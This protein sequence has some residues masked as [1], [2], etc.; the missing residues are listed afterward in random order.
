MRCI[1]RVSH[2]EDSLSVI[3]DEN[4]PMATS[5][6][7]TFGREPT[8]AQQAAAIVRKTEVSEY[9]G[10]TVP[11]SHRFRLP[12]HDRVLALAEAGGV[13][14]SHMLEEVIEAGLHAIEQELGKRHLDKIGYWKTRSMDVAM[15]GR[16]K[17]VG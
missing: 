2:G 17:A 12:N 14:F 7:T 16:K 6:K 3:N 9:A 8:P 15:R 13:P 1:L 5:T 10:L 11:R 4:P